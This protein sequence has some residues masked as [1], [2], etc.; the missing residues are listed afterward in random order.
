MARLQSNAEL[1]KTL[2]DLSKLLKESTLTIQ[3]SAREVRDYP[4]DAIQRMTDRVEQTLTRMDEVARNC[5][6][7]ALKAQETY[8]AARTVMSKNWREHVFWMCVTAL[9][10]A[11][12]TGILFIWIRRLF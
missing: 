12:T 2:Q 4:V 11:L 9:M 1:L 10:T 8:G 7:S 6:K 5:E 3:G